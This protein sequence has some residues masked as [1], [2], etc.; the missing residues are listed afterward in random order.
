MKTTRLLAAFGVLLAAVSCSLETDFTPSGETPSDVVVSLWA[1]SDADATR[2]SLD[3]NGLILWSAGD[4]IAVFSESGVSYDFTAA[5]DGARS[6]FDHTGEVSGIDK[7]YALY[8]YNASA[9]VSGNTVT[10]VIPTTQTA[11]AGSFGPDANVAVAYSE[12]GSFNFRNAVGYVKVSFRTTDESPKIRKA[13]FVSIDGSVLLS[14][15]AEITVNPD[16]DEAPATVSVREGVN[17]V[18]VE[19]AD[20]GYLLPDTD[21]YIAAAPAALTGGYRIEFEDEDGNAF[22]RDYDGD[23]YKAASIKRNAFAPVGKKNLDDYTLEGWWRLYS[24][25]DKG[26]GNYL[27]VNKMSDGS[28]RILNEDRSDTYIVKGTHFELS[29][30]SMVLNASYKRAQMEGMV[31]YVFRNAY[32]SSSADADGITFAS[33]RL[34]C[35]GEDIGIEVKSYVS[36]RVTYYYANITL[37][38]RTDNTTTLLTLD[39]LACTLSDSGTGLISGKFNT[40]STSVNPGGNAD[41]CSDLVDALLLHASFSGY[42]SMV[43]NAAVNALKGDDNAFTGG[44]T[45][46]SHTTKN[47]IV[48]S[49]HFMIKTADLL[50]GA[51]IDEVCLYKKGE[52][53]YSAYRQ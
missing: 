13:R 43:K 1:T 30:S 7:A 21:Y 52:K 33:D 4:R 9:T 28:Y 53:T 25:D 40:K 37:Y 34:I 18:E 50:S 23:T 47:N 6:R 24:G 11:R 44:F 38:N 26:T 19:A 35:S 46:A 48:C 3:E 36:A 42:D 45:T 10:T 49:N 22:G 12:T 17:Y 2:S 29:G 32:L 20:G 31:A 51:S 39:N 15:T 41:S 5:S 16:S 27:V 8:P 14:G